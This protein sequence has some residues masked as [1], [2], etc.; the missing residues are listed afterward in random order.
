M[1]TLKQERLPSKKG[2]RLDEH[3]LAIFLETA[4]GTE[5]GEVISLNN[6][7]AKFIWWAGT[8]L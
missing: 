2:K 6:I 3:R 5:E 7:E 1:V 8:P 4:M